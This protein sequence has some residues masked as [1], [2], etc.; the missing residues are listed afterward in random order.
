MALFNEHSFWDGMREGS[1]MK[2]RNNIL[3]YEAL[4]GSLK[5]I[6]IR[7]TRFY[8]NY[9]SMF[10]FPF[11]VN[12]PEELEE[13]FDWD[14][15]KRLIAGSYSSEMR[16]EINPEWKKNPTDEIL[17]DIYIKVKYG[18]GGTE[19]T[20]DELW[21]FQFIRLFEI[22]IEEQM[23]MLVAVYE[24][25]NDDYFEIDED[26]DEEEITECD[27]SELKPVTDQNDDEGYLG[28]ERNIRIL[29]FL[30]QIDHIYTEF[31]KINAKKTSEKEID[32]LELLL[33]EQQEQSYTSTHQKAAPKDYKKEP[34]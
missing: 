22:Y 29:K 27:V 25:D 17:V 8:R 23:N 31:E 11:R 13:D 9:L 14:L 16:L 2:K 7:Q 6:D 28:K 26:E 21:S 18:N 19:K 34:Q 1:N 20:L 12:I 4:F 33:D 15:L 32:S 24:D 10:N 30:Q 5:D 3:K